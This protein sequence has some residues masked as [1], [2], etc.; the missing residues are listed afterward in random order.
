MPF[1]Y[2][3]N[4]LRAIAV[5]AVV[6]FHFNPTWIPGGFAGVDVFFVISGFLMTSIIFNGIDKSSFNLFEFY[7]ARAN[8]IIPVL[9]T[10][11]FLLIVFGMF[12]LV[13]TDLE[14]L[15]KQVQKSSTFTSNLLFSKGGGYF[16]TNEKTKWLLHTWSLSIEWQFYIFFPVIILL[17]KR[18]ISVQNIK[19]IIIGLFI[20]SFCYCVF[21]TF[22]NSKTAY[23]LLTCRAWEMLLGGLAFLYPIIIQSIKNKV[24]LQTTGIAL[25]VISY[26]T[27]SSHT[28]WP[29]YMALMPVFGTYLILISNFQKNPIINNLFFN[30]IGKWSYSIYVWHWPIVVFGVYF[31]IQ[32]WWLYGI[33]L[34]ILSGYFSYQFIEKIRFKKFFAWKDIY[35]VKPF[36]IF[37]FIFILGITVRKTDGLQFIYSEKIREITKESQNSNP[38]KCDSSSENSNLYECIVGDTKNIK[39]IIIGDSHADAITTALA[40]TFDLKKEGIISIASSGCPFIF[41]V[42]IGLDDANYNCLNIN[43]L[44]M[45]WLVD[46][47]DE[48]KNLPIIIAARW[49]SYLKPENDPERIIGENRPL[50]HAES[51]DKKQFNDLNSIFT[52]KLESTLC[53][54]NTNFQVY[55]MQPIPEMAKNIPKTMS[56]NLL[57]GKSP[58][59]SISYQEYL[60]RSSDV[61]SIIKNVAQRCNVKTL[62]PAAVLCKSGRCIADDKGR[63]IYRDGDHLSEYGNKLLTPMFK[64][65]LL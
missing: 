23:F 5:L 63:P 38:Y 61:R 2:D 49:S 29:G 44:R 36:Y 54:I 31:S 60:E 45:R 47:Q 15:G 41:D 25:I 24:L 30:H 55:I 65:A 14:N 27:F 51:R 59:L 16:D 40:T 9:A 42:K 21:A 56:K 11:S 4:G 43:K 20:L 26:F 7:T 39:A 3:I 8:R 13:P 46:H 17:L 57:L 33:P 28:P 35:K 6:F 50:M 1:R 34:S 62:D 37:L 19:K 64:Q 18:Y 53:P 12:F 58:D 10:V 52:R 22:K 32:H 48:Y